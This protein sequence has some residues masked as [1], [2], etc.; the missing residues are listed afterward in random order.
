MMAEGTIIVR[1]SPDNPDYLLIEDI[2]FHSNLRPLWKADARQL[3][4]AL[5]EALG[6]YRHADLCDDTACPC[7]A[8]RQSMLSVSI[9]SDIMEP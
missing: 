1:E 4:K 5:G 9:A 3:Y 8:G 7:R 2:P 6:L